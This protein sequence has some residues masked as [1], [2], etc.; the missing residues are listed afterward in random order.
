MLTSLSYTMR[1]R[2]FVV[3]GLWVT[4]MLP[5]V[6]TSDLSVVCSLLTHVYHLTSSVLSSDLLTCYFLARPTCYVWLFVY[7][8]CHA[9][10][11]HPAWYTWLCDYHVYGNPVLLL[12]NKVPHHTRWGP[13]LESVGATSRI[14]PL[15]TK[16]HTILG[17]GHL[18]N[19]LGYS[20]YVQ[21]FP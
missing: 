5:F 6:I 10:S 2:P 8:H 1:G 15:R 18:L 13:P 14:H 17:G 20:C 3:V 16:C 9:I 21:L 11:L 19:L 12:W 4:S 7:H